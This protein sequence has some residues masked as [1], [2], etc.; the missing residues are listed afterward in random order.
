MRSRTFILGLVCVAGCHAANNSGESQGPAPSGSTPE[1]VEALRGLEQETGTRWDLAVRPEDHT[2]RNLSGRTAKLLT[3]K[4]QGF[5]TSVAFLEKNRA[6]FKMRDPRRELRTRRER[7][8]ELGMFHVRMQQTVRGVPV[9]GKEVM[10]HFDPKGRLVEISANYVPDLDGVDVNPTISLE[11]AKAVAAAEAGRMY[12]ELV[13]ATFEVEQPDLM[14]YAPEQGAAR[15]GH[16]F[17]LRSTDARI[18]LFDCMIDAKTGAVLNQFDDLQHVEGSGTGATGKAHKIEVSAAGGGYS[19]T[20]A[21]RGQGIRTFD[22]NHA[23]QTPGTLETSTSLT[24][25]DTNAADGAGAAVDA[26]AYASAVYDF[27]KKTFNRNGLDGNNTAMIST[28]HYGQAYD[29]A[30]WD[31]R[32]M[33]YGDG[34][35]AFKAPLCSSV[36]VVAHEFTH[37]VTSSE[38]NL[39]YQNASGA[40]NEAI[41]DIFGV[42]IKHSLNPTD[43]NFFMLGT[44]VAT[45]G[46]RNM[47]DPAVKQQP[48][49]MTQYV[50]TQQDNGGVH[51]N[52]GIINNAFYLMTVSGT[53][54][55]SQVAVQFGI[56]WEKSQKVWYRASTELLTS[57]SDF[58]AAAAATIRASKDLALTENEQNIV[59]CAWIATG[60]M[61]GTCKTLSNPATPAPAP[62]T[63][64]PAP[65]TDTPRGETTSSSSSS[66][67]GTSTNPGRTGTTSGA[68]D[69][70][71]DGEEEEEESTT[72]STKKRKTITQTSQGCSTA[73]GGTGNTSGL[74]LAFAAVALTV[75]ARR[76]NSR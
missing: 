16:H 19:M 74:L 57:Q 13:G 28:V 1:Q 76:R 27:Y 12:P 49:H 69:A 58:A 26:H 64:A 61:A 36:D 9:W 14:V 8:D 22:A 30:F 73:P 39:V 71:E 7:S 67:G 54:P 63:P 48:G 68:N 38:S 55:R 70:E 31:G 34:G 60:V 72:S 25:W 62:T 23:Q 66:T 47:K 21:T 40:L 51:I 42:M 11:Q 65:T 10:T 32:Q 15:V 4:E 24:S 44:E 45:G 50:R 20:D 17:K 18:A 2:A 3:S 29:N 59:E 41:S 5:E 33:A 46:L 6:I 43:P 37:G 53:N 52:S 75:G 35:Q 56:G